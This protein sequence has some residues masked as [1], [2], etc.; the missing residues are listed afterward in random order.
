[1]LKKRRERK[2]AEEERKQE[3]EEYGFNP[4]NDVGGG[5]AGAASGAAAALAASRGSGP[6]MDEVSGG[7][8]GWGNTSNHGTKLS[9]G[10]TLSDPGSTGSGGATMLEDDL[11]RPI[12]SG[13]G[14]AN[15]AYGPGVTGHAMPSQHPAMG[16]MNRGM[17]MPMEDDGMPASLAIN[18]GPGTAVA[19]AT[20]PGAGTEL[21]QGNAA[22]Q[23][24][25]GNH[26]AQGSG[27][28]GMYGY[29][30]PGA[31]AVMRNNTTSSTSSGNLTRD[32]SGAARPDR[33]PRR[34]PSNA[35]SAYSGSAA[36]N[37]DVSDDGGAFAD[38]ARF[39]N[40]G[41]PGMGNNNG[42]TQYNTEMPANL[43]HQQP[44]PYGQAVELHIPGS[45]VPDAGAGAY[46]GGFPARAQSGG[47]DEYDYND[48][49]R[50]SQIYGPRNTGN[51]GG[52][53][54]NF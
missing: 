1:M 23:G 11:G 50:G 51:N 36:R 40:Y 41:A 7:Y 5:G 54:V 12:S 39:S 8:R 38:Q 19:A 3:L 20:I 22:E 33:S 49:Y 26:N 6:A 10:M 35:S 30:A 44:N 2:L 9:T 42:F 24:Y 53:Y 32:N 16:G 52:S 29:G 45:G 13:E 48:A 15:Y 4:N 18:R 25:M 28:S 14:F 34:G 46:Q 47:Y 43:H 17:G 21:P 37:S 27:E 31:A